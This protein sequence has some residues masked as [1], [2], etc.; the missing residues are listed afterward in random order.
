M[1]EKSKNNPHPESWLTIEG[2][3]AQAELLRMYMKES[4]SVDITHSNSLEAVSRSNGFGDWNTAS[5]LI[6]RQ[7]EILRY[8]LDDTNPETYPSG[9][10]A[11][12]LYVDKGTIEGR[13]WQTLSGSAVVPAKSAGIVTIIPNL[14]PYF[15]PRAVRIYGYDEA[16]PSLNRRFVVN[17]VEVGKSPQLAAHWPRL[18]NASVGALSDV[19]NRSGDPLRVLWSLFSTRGLARELEIHVYNINDK[20]IVVNATTFGKG[21]TSIDCYT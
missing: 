16:K 10:T 6:K 11:L 2:M 12:G 4:L 9:G 8:L 15:E 5:G 13:D 18:D 21:V 17:A 20:P 1:N 3:K 14:T 7:D 19:F